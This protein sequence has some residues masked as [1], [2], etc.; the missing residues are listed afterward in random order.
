MVGDCGRDQRNLCHLWMS[1][2]VAVHQE[3]DFAR[4]SDLE[5][6]QGGICVIGGCQFQCLSGSPPSSLT[7]YRSLGVSQALAI[8]AELP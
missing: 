6:C 7:V 1:V 8:L 2:A 5:D 4:G 3:A